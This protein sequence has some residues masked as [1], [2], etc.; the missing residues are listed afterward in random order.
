MLLNLYKKCANALIGT[1][2]SK[3]RIVSKFHRFISNKFKPEFVIVENKKF[4]LDGNDAHNLAVFG[5]RYKKYYVEC[6]LKEAKKDSVAL[7][8][9]ANIGYFTIFLADVIGE[10]GKVFAVEPEQENVELLKK[11][12]LANDL[13]NIEVIPKAISMHNEKVKFQI[14]KMSGDHTIVTDENSTNTIEMDAI[15]IDEYFT[16]VLSKINFVIFTIEGAELKALKG[17]T[18]TLRQSKELT[19]MTEFYPEKIRSLGDSPEEFIK[20]LVE[21]GFE[22]FDLGDGI[23]PITKISL[24]KIFENMNQN[25]FYRTDLLCKLKK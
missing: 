4:Y 14:S 18:E 12:I 5:G 10:K 13:Q 11:N 8:L 3:Y 9:G 17:M 7:S 2:I 1:G 15:G 25:K 19:L 24:E 6:M 21:H 20:L 16:D 23:T 22:I